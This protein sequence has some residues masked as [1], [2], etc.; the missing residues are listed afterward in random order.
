M[1][2]KEIR[3]MQRR[4][5]E[6]IQL[7]HR[8]LWARAGRSRLALV[9]YRGGKVIEIVPEGDCETQPSDVGDPLFR[10]NSLQ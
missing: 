3:R 1:T 9:V 10:R 4:I 8:R 7:A 2:D 5:D 6:G